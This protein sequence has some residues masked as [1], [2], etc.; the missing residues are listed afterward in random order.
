MWSAIKPLKTHLRT[1]KNQNYPTIT[2]RHNHINKTS[3]AKAEQRQHTPKSN[4]QIVL[5]LYIWNDSKLKF[6]GAVIVYSSSVISYKSVGIVLEILLRNSRALPF[7]SWGWH[8]TLWSASSGATKVP[9]KNILSCFLLVCIVN[10]RI[11][12]ERRPCCIKF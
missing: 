2:Y 5:F 3:R 4:R 9:I 1:Q 12:W 8:V 11:N 10:K 6:H 7:F